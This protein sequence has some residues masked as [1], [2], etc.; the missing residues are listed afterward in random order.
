MRGG[1]EGVRGTAGRGGVGKGS[2]PGTRRYERL[3]HT[4]LICTVKVHRP[5]G[6]ARAGGGRRVAQAAAPL[7]ARP[8]QRHALGAGLSPLLSPRRELSGERTR[9]A[10]TSRSLPERG[11]RKAHMGREEGRAREGI[12]PP[13]SLDCRPSNEHT[14][15]ITHLLPLELSPKSLNL[16]THPTSPPIPSPPL[17][18]SA[19][20]SPCCDHCSPRG[21]PPSST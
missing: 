7:R 6:R 19:T 21:P 11:R 16:S 14:C 3:F 9:V 8:P 15:L 10:K 18:P 12:P 13:P 5:S 1:A 20:A 2:R 4:T 17:R